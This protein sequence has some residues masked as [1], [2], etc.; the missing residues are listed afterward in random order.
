M[1]CEIVG[2]GD[3][4][5]FRENH[6]Q[7]AFLIAADG[8][9]THL[10]KIGIKPDLIIGDFDSIGEIPKADYLISLPKEK[11][12]TDMLVAVEEGIK[13][14]Y[15]EIH[16]FGGTGG[17]L[18]HTFANIQVLVSLAEKKY[19]GFLYEK[20]M[21]LTV[22]KNRKFVIPARQKGIA[23]VFSITDI[24]KGVDVHGLKYE[25]NNALLRNSYPIGVSNEFCGQDV[26]ISV[27]EGSLLI[28][29]EASVRSDSKE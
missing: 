27:Q 9:Y 23:S 17:R 11:D 13:H 4:V 2:A 22:I 7:D 14:G 12:D 25:L 6:Q 19:Q 24:A 20:N 29:F 28:M 3:F 18:D 26:E 1:R 21:V 15:K 16:L 8:G 5:C 10:N